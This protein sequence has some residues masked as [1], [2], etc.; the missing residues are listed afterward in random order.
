[1]AEVRFWNTLAVEDVER[2]RA[3]YSALGFTVGDVPGM[4]GVTVAP[5]EGY[6]VCL[7]STKAFAGMIPGGICDTRRSQE[8]VQSM[9]VDS[10]E[11]VDALAAK[12]KAAGAH[13]IGEPK[14]QPY[15]YGCGFADPDG[16]VWAVL[17]MPPPPS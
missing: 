1:M 4:E 8:I 11:G 10:R 2:A 5:S 17:W 7:F 6:L 9:S 15:G 14:D 16:H 13:M 12:A 3:F